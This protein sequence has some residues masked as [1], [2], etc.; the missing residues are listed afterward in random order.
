MGASRRLEVMG[1]AGKTRA[2]DGDTGEREE[3]ALACRPLARPFFLAPNTSKR[4]LRR[5]GLYHDLIC[6]LC[7]DLEKHFPTVDPITMGSCSYFSCAR[8]FD[9]NFRFQN[10]TNF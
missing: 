8:C 9:V 4:L 3:G 1:A 2:R 5:L 10:M 6:E 7:L